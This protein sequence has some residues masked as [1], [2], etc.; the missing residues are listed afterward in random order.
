MNSGYVYILTNESMEGLIKIGKT[1]RDSQSRA[2]ELQDTGVPTPFHVAFEI[3]CDDCDSVEK[4]IHEKLDQYRVRSNR[5]FFKYSLDN[6]IAMLQGSGKT[7]EEYEYSA[8]DITAYLMKKYP[9][10]MRTDILSIRII[11]RKERVWLEITEEEKRDDNLVNQTIQRTDLGIIIDFFS[12]VDDVSINAKKFIEQLD[13]C[14]II[15]T[16]DLFDTEYYD[17]VKK[18]HC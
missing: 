11:Q 8:M 12:P 18:K 16:T 4:D 7:I 6:A 17:E 5:E 3:F 15:M 13:P 2:R 9:T 1:K 10:W 14:A